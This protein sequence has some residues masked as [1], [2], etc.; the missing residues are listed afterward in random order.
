MVLEA[1][2][3]A[4]ATPSRCSPTATP[5]GWNWCR[6]PRRRWPTARSVTAADRDGARRLLVD[7]ITGH[8]RRSAGALHRSSPRATRCT[9][10]PTRSTTRPCSMSGDGA[11]TATLDRAHRR[12][13][14]AHRVGGRPGAGEGDGPVVVRRA[15]VLTE[16]GATTRW[17][18]GPTLASHAQRP[19]VTPNLHL[20]RSTANGASPPRC[21]CPAGDRPTTTAHR[22]RC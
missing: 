20:H 10:S 1:E 3:A 15:A 11:A 4:T 22:C 18:A 14:R 6:A 2:P 8:P 13:R 16:H 19:L 7:G 12:A 5:P 9:C 17:W 21:C